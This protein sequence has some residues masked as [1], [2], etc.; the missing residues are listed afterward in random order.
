LYPKV[1]VLLD[2]AILVVAGGEDGKQL[3]SVIPFERAKKAVFR[4]GLKNYTTNGV[5][6][7]HFTAAST[8]FYLFSYAYQKANWLVQSASGI[9]GRLS[10]PLPECPSAQRPL[11]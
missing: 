1:L 4:F 10:V 7:G 8:V 2:L 11:R 9:S 5:G 6:M 3:I